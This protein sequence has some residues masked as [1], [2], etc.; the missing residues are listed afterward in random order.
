MPSRPSR[1]LDYFHEIRNATDA[2]SYI[3]SLH[4]PTDPTFEDDWRDFKQH[5]GTANEEK[6][7]EIWSEALSGFANTGGGVLVW[8][9]KAKTET[10]ADGTKLDAVCSIEPFPNPSGMR[11]LLLSLR[12]SMTDPPVAGVEVVPIDDPKNL[13]RGFVACY[14]PESG[15]KPHRMEI[16]G[17]KDYMFRAGDSFKVL[18]TPLLRNLF[19]PFRVSTFSVRGRM[20]SHIPPSRNEPLCGVGFEVVIANTGSGSA[21]DLCVVVGAQPSGWQGHDWGHRGWDRLG[22]PGGLNAFQATAPLHPG[23]ERFLFGLNVKAPITTR[24]GGLVVPA[25]LR[26]ELSFTFHATDQPRQRAGLTFDS[27]QAVNEGQSD[28]EATAEEA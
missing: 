3:Y 15:F 8:G 5:P 21:R 20:T 22:Y 9:V 17:R 27:V 10:L 4:N 13:G 12:S 7:K 19:F 23:Q 28:R 18:P 16:K 11:A 14:V 26:P 1:A 2:A 24:E 6:V 25:F